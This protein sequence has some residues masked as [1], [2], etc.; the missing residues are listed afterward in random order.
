MR[1]ITYWAAPDYLLL[2]RIGAP[3]STSI[4]L[5]RWTF[6]IRGSA[7]LRTP[8]GYVNYT[9]VAAASRFRGCDAARGEA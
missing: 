5:P 3:R 1:K 7:R 4:S 6:Y 9:S 8:P 2:R